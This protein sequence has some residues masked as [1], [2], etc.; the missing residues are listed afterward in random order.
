[1]NLVKFY[2]K[3]FI[4]TIKQFLLIFRKSIFNKILIKNY[5]I[6]HKL[7]IFALIFNK[8]KINI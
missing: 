5:N 1:M 6:R 8:I 2:L 4:V 7:F 3:T